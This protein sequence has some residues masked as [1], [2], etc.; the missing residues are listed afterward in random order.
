MTHRQCFGAADYLSAWSKKLAETTF[1]KF[2]WKTYRKYELKT[3]PGHDFKWNTGC[4]T[5]IGWDENGDFLIFDIMLFDNS[6][7]DEILKAVGLNRNKLQLD[8]D[9]GKLRFRSL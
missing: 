7:V 8:F 6:T 4:T 9:M 2:T 1:P 3:V 5:T